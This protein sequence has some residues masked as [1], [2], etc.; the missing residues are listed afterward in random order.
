M[1]SNVKKQYSAHNGNY[2][3]PPCH[4]QV[5]NVGIYVSFNFSSKK[6]TAFLLSIV[7]KLTKAHQHD[8]EIPYT[9]FHQKS[10]NKCGQ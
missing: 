3:M 4:N 2:E 9:E 1:F 5:M 7:M 6:S 10:N 8:V